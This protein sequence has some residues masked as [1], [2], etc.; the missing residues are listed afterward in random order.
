MTP[1]LTFLFT[2]LENSTGLWQQAPA[3]MQDALARHDAITQAAVKDHNGR[4]VKTTGDGLHAVFDSAADGVTAAIAMQLALVGQDWPAE[5]GPLK[6]RI[7]LHTGESQER[8]GDFYGPAV[9]TAARVMDLGHGGQILLSEVTVLLL[10]GQGLAD[11]TFRDL[12][13]HQLKGVPDPERI[14]QLDHPDLA[15]DFQPLRSASVPKHNLPA[16]AAPLLGRES[17][18]GTLSGLLADSEHPLVTIVAPGGTGK[19]HLALELGRRLVANFS[20]GV[21][22]VELAPINESENIIPAVAEAVGYR[23]QQ[24]GRGQEQQMLDYLA[25]KEMLLILDNYE[26]LL[27]G[28]TAIAAELLHSAPGLRILATSR[29][30]LHLPEETLFTL[31]GLSLPEGGADDAFHNASVELFQQSARR[32]QPGFDLTPENLPHIVQIC[33]LAHGMPLGILLAAAW[34]PVISP[35]EIAAEIQQGLDILEA[36]GSELPERQRSVRAVF[37]QAWGMM[38]EAE[39]NVFMK[40]AVF[41]GGFTRDAGQMVAGAGL[42]QLQS[43]VNKALLE[44]SAAQERYYVHELLRQ[45]G[46]EKL[47]QSGQEQQVREAHCAYYLA[48]LAEQVA[49]L[50]GAEQ[51]PTLEK[52]ETDFEN[53]REAWEN[54]VRERAFDLLGG[55][56][57]A[58]YLFCY[59]RSRLEDGKSLFG[60]A[61]QGLAPEAGEAP[62]P[63]WLAAGIRF[64]PTG[65]SQLELK[66]QLEASLA[67]ARAR[68]D[69]LEMAYCLHTL[70]TIAHYVDQDPARAIAFYEECAAIYRRLGELFYLA[71]ALSKLG[72]A[73]QLLGQTERTVAYV[74]EAYELQRRIGDYIGESETLRA[75][76]MTAAQ[77]GDYAAMVDLQEKAY[78]IQLQTDY[79][80]GQATSN[81]YLGWFKYFEGR[82]QEGR[83]QVE[84]GLELALEV[85]D[86]SAQAWCYTALGLF[87]CIAGD[88]AGA[89]QE[90]ARAE[91]IVTDPFRQTGAGNPFLQMLAELV[92][93]L[94]DAAEGDFTSAR[95]H[96]LQPL[97]LSI[98]TASQ[99]FMTFI[100]AFAALV[101]GNDGRPEEAAELL[102]LALDNPAAFLNWMREYAPLIDLQAELRESLGQ[103]GFEAA[104]ERGRQMNLMATLQQFL[105]DIESG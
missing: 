44:R 31:H 64:Y 72:E 39:R 10:R 33:R 56:L 52:I 29:Y 12:G 59:L 90:L 61:W 79:R 23:F 95:T 8:A 30:R 36:E 68:G 3:A 84:L 100:A 24:N 5:T 60:K 96:L 89:A 37:D 35:A 32:V 45:Y 71:Q 20:S 88:Y 104:W 38:D 105:K 43:L 17:E 101:Y 70:A 91:A 19:S 7:G 54:S 99:P 65:G 51:L 77:T 42:R 76:S 22:F 63:V 40:T 66:E 85:A 47:G 50:K 48:Y 53:I 94:L 46:E 41:R 6:V 69:E 34:V 28:G 62:H 74:Q 102:G 21:Y 98:M 92:K 57:E 80:V 18:I 13:A 25:N 103:E 1:L 26:H 15:H 93:F 2:D 9:N 81:L 55:A 58:L 11:I 67:Q 14:F 82:Y 86:F 87:D 78:I 73:H 75:L 27:D 83:R 49:P 97:T 4:I 16:G